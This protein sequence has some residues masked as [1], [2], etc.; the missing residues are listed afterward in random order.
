MRIRQGTGQYMDGT[1]LRTLLEELKIQLNI[2]SYDFIVAF[3]AIQAQR[4]R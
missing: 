1:W 2:S 4:K 3:L